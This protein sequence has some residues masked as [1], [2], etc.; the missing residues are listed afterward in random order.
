MLLVPRVLLYLKTLLLPHHFLAQSK[1][2]RLANS[3]QIVSYL[4]GKKAFCFDHFFE[5]YIFAW[6]STF[7]LQMGLSQE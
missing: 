1:P 2:R 7:L 4:K 3:S 6:Q 5:S